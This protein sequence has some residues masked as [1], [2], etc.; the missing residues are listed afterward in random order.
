MRSAQ[1]PEHNL[2]TKELGIAPSLE[3]VLEATGGSATALKDHIGGTEGPFYV[4][5]AKKEYK[6]T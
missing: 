2:L 5:S 1:R 6:D 3:A 4:T